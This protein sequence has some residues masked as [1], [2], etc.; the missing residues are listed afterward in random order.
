MPSFLRLGSW[1]IVMFVSYEQIKRAVVEFQRYFPVWQL[2]GTSE[3]PTVVPK[4]GL[5]VSSS[6]SWR[7][8][9]LVGISACLDPFFL[10]NKTTHAA[11]YSNETAGMISV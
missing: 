1:N 9:S 6:T 5:S 8:E 7:P 11:A 4:P 2:V 3:V 10:S